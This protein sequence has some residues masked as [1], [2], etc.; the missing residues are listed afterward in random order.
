MKTIKERFETMNFRTRIRLG[1]ILV[2]FLITGLGILVSTYVRGRDQIKTMNELGRYIA[3]NLSKNSVLGILSEE[4][5]NLEQPLRAVLSNEQVW[6]ASVYSAAGKLIKAMHRRQDYSLNRPCSIKQLMLTAAAKD[7]VVI[8]QTKTNFGKPIRSYFSKVTVEQS[9]DDVFTVEAPDKQLCG[10]VRVD[11]SLDELS[12]RKAAV[13]WSSLLLM[14]VYIGI[15]ILCSVEVERHISKPLIG[16]KAAAV[17][18]AQGDFSKKMNAKAKDEIG[19]LAETFNTMSARLSETITEL[20]YSNEQLE[21][22]NKELQDFTYVI[23]HDLQ[24]PLRKV[25]SFGQ[26][27]LEDCEGQLSEDGQDYIGRMQAA[28][29][30]MKHLIQ[31]LLKLSRVGTAEDSFTRIN[32]NEIVNSALDD[33]SIAIKENDAEIIVGQLPDV[34]GQSTLLTQL[35]ENLIGNA[36]KYRRDEISPRIE[37][38]ATRR[39]G[40]VTFSVKD[41]GVGIEER[42]L[43]K[44]FGVFQRLHTGTK[45]SGTGIGLALCRKIVRRHNGEI[46]ARSTEGKGTTFNFTLKSYSG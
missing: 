7:E 45:Y 19:A 32:T 23:S 42:F 18:M 11:M 8:C 10:F 29:T 22:A 43:E 21:K 6:G 37:I 41:N 33:L 14:P 39:N 4:Q 1:I 5:T 46:W 28:S 17:A 9:A 16:L 35:F 30:K 40:Q 34:L 24:E 2:I 36:L 31:D 3:L 26:F 27:L 15:G 44:V 13:F 25:H 12:A 38:Y 20:N